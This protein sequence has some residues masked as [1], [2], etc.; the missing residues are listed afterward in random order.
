[1]ASTLLEGLRKAMASAGAPAMNSG[2]A[3]STDQTSLI[4]SLTAAKT[5]KALPES[6]AP[7]M[8]SLGEEQ[9]QAQTATA[10]GSLQQAGQAQ[11]LQVQ[12][13]EEK[14]DQAARI[15]GRQ[16]DER[17]LDLADE[18]NRRTDGILADYERNGQKLDL[19]R[20]KARAEQLGFNLRLSNSRYMD[21]LR[22]AGRRSR[23]DNAIAFKDELTR[24]VFADEQELFVNDLSFR[25]LMR[26]DDRTFA[27]QMAQM[28]IDYALQ[29]A[30]TENK[31]ANM[32]MMWSGIGG[33]TQ[34]G[35]QGYGAYKSGAFDREVSTDPDLSTGSV[36][37][38]RASERY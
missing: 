13:A 32:Q 22:D 11:A 34:A 31:Q 14:V 29:I 3:V 23:L 17:E 9:A 5:G 28:D 26:A 33:L 18:L 25:H 8:S 36:G 38:L 19:T 27:D 7:R 20:N 16:L 10:L 21:D 30:E 6:S 35:I 15:E 24:A 2:P 4:S 12:Q 1:M 37:D